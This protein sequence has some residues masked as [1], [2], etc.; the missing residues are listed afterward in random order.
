MTWWLDTT[1]DGTISYQIEALVVDGEYMATVRD[2][3]ENVRCT[4]PMTYSQSSFRHRVSFPRSCFGNPET[5][6]FQNF[7]NYAV[8]LFGKI[9]YFEDAAPD[10]WNWSSSAYRARIATSLSS[11]VSAS[12]VTYGQTPTVSGT[13][14]VPAEVLA[15]MYPPQARYTSISIAYQVA[16]AIF[17]GL[18]PL[19]IATWVFGTD[20]Q[21]GNPMPWVILAVIGVVGAAA[22]ALRWMFTRYRVTGEYVELRTGVLVRN[23]RS[24]RRDRIRSVDLDAKSWHRIVGLRVLTIGAGQQAAAGE[25]AFELDAVSKTEAEKL[26]QLLALSSSAPIRQRAREGRELVPGPAPD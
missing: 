26:R 12:T 10:D 11:T 23:H 2:V 4:K 20:F 6:S 17:G 5:V 25:S 16:G 24:V 9:R 18:A 14:L 21:T 7:S 19:A 3:D 15:Q 13:S 8:T 22:D 1:G